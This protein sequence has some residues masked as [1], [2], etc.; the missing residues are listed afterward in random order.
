MLLNSAPLLFDFIC[1]YCMDVRIRE[2][3]QVRAWDRHMAKRETN[4]KWF[5]TNNIRAVKKWERIGR[6]ALSDG[7]R[8]SSEAPFLLISQNFA[9]KSQPYPLIPSPTLSV[10][11][12]YTH[13]SAS[14]SPHANSRPTERGW[15][16]LS[17]SAASLKNSL[18]HIILRGKI[19]VG[20]TITVNHFLSPCCSASGIPCIVHSSP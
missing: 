19:Q 18:L 14:S 3:K 9:L 10:L 13:S 1:P 20:D 15:N 11:P 8:Q 5:E 12:P 17:S 7:W 2:S 4:I 16:C 6:H